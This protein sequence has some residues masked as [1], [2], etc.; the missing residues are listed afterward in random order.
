MWN[1][2]KMAVG[3]GLWVSVGSDM[4]ERMFEDMVPPTLDMWL[5][6]SPEDW[7]DELAT[8]LPGPWM[9]GVLE[10][11][12]DDVS[13]DAEQEKLLACWDRFLPWAQ[14]QRAHA[15]V[16]AARGQADVE[17]PFGTDDLGAEVVA[18]LTGDTVAAA[19]HELS[20]ARML[21][22]ELHGCRAALER[23]EIT[24]R[25]AHD[26]ANATAHLPAWQREIVDSRMVS[27]WEIDRD[28]KKWRRKLRR[29]V[30][31]VDD[32][33][34]HRRNRAITDRHVACWPLPDGMACVHAEL[35][36]EDAATVMAALTALAD[37]YGAEDR[38]AAAAATAANQ[39]DTDQPDTDGTDGPE[40]WVDPESFHALARAAAQVRTMDQRRADALVDICA[41]ALAD[42]TLPKRQGRRPTVQ[43]T[44]GILTLL[45]LRNDPGE[46][47]GYG[48]IT[49]QHLREL[50][51]DGDWHRFL[52][53]PDTGALISIGTTTYRPNQALRDFMV[54]AEPTCDFPGCGIPSQRTDAEHTLSHRDGGLTDED[55]VCPRCRRHHRCKTHA[56]WTVRRLPDGS[57]E[58]TTPCGSRR[59][60]TPHR[61]A[62]DETDDDDEPGQLAS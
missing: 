20:T 2:R 59:I 49:A 57:I 17:G 48:P 25:M 1:C 12:R 55:N 11:L 56:G 5:T 24:W 18:L 60:I 42:P 31:R 62:G 38:A 7:L 19:G 13:T 10:G 61:L 35:K 28:I 43:V 30:L 3:K 26:V 36:A 50:A 29:E 40:D 47:A 52:T 21:E 37:S 27:K 39:P 34:E 46:L 53:A 15:M 32:N 44:G 54:A 23:G 58:W 33:A 14:A 22:S 8:V 45:G 6:R 51:A 4:I 41:D 9:L 16:G